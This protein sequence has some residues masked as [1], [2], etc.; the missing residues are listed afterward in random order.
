MGTDLVGTIEVQQGGDVGVWTLAVTPAG[1][2]QGRPHL[3]IEWLRR[4]LGVP[5]YCTPE[6]AAAIADLS[7]PSF[8]TLEDL[9][10]AFEDD[11]AEGWIW[12]LYVLMHAIRRNNGV[13]SRHV[14]LVFA[15]SI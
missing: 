15:L 1:I 2:P 9:E 5:E 11:D 7:E 10:D 13:K 3:A 14:R 12:D 6:S 8:T 4:G